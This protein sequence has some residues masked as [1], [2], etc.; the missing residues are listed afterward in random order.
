MKVAPAQPL[1]KYARVFGSPGTRVRT[2]GILRS[3]WPM[4]LVFIGLGYLIRAALPV[5]PLTPTATGLLFFALAIAVA[6][7]ANF[8]RDRLQNYIKGARGEESVARAL[9]LLPAHWNIF[10]GISG[11]RGIRDGGGAD[12]DHIA[13]GP[14]A[15][16]VIETKNWSGDITAEHN[17]LLCEGATPDRDPLEQVKATVAM[18]RRRLH[19][20][21]GILETDLPLVPVL[22]FAGGNVLKGLTGLAGVIICTDDRLCAILQL[23][24][25][26]HLS[27][28]NRKAVIRLL[29]ADVEH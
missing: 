4:I 10:H 28:E 13:V 6:A 29:T 18:L 5:P 11:N 9:A 12:I 7:A 19:E 23:H 16:F 15:I 1:R 3:F 21:G 2:M 25:E 27:E 17:T 8:S 22:C 24:R 20:A 26:T 14:N